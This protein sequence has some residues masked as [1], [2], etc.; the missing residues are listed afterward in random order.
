MLI[1]HYVLPTKNRVSGRHAEEPWIELL[2]IYTGSEQT[3]REFRTSCTSCRTTGRIETNQIY[4]ILFILNNVRVNTIITKA[5]AVRRY[6]IYKE[7][8]S[9][10][11]VFEIRILS[12]QLFI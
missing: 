12:I 5:S 4:A 11:N 9:Y 1:L 10:L 2:S 6:I 7:T 8:C 3:A